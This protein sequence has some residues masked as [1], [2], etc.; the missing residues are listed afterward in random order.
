VDVFPQTLQLSNCQQAS[1][2][3][4]YLGEQHRDFRTL[5]I[6]R[7]GVNGAKGCKSALVLKNTTTKPVQLQKIQASWQLGWRP[8][9]IG[10]TLYAYFSPIISENNTA[11]RVANRKSPITGA[12][13]SYPC[14]A[15]PRHGGAY[16]AIPSHAT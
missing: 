3:Q 5:G 15:A 8:F 1:V 7:A 2:L 10:G 9:R 11:T 12:F 16:P 6:S 4:G 14:H 13:P